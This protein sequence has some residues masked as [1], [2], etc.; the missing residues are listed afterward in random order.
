[1]KAIEQIRTSLITLGVKGTVKISSSDMDR[2]SVSLN[3]QY[4]GM[5]DAVANTFVD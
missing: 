3:N 1:M 5:F 2:Y 4:F